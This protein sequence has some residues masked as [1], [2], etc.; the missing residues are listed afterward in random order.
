MDEHSGRLTV[1]S[2][3]VCPFCD[4]GRR[5]LEE[6]QETRDRDL[7]IDWQPFDLRRQKRGLDGE[8]ARSVDDGK[9]EAYF[10]Q[11]RGNVVRRIS[12]KRTVPAI[13]DENTGVTMSESANIVDYLDTTYG[14]EA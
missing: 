2:D 5:S 14:A 8:V 1:Y 7:E 10:D 9:D 12:G 4:P 3:Y 11:V 13:V 6:Y